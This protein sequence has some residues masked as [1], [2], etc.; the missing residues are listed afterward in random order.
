VSCGSCGLQDV[1]LS[2]D[3]ISGFC[4]ETEEHHQDT[5]SLL[6]EVRYCWATVDYP[7]AIQSHTTRV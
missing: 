7:A 2:S 4:G 3:F 1:G 5:L 6:R